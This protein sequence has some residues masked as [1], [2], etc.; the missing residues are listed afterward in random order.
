MSTGLF[1]IHCKCL[2]CVSY[3]CGAA[4]RCVRDKGTTR[5][6]ERSCLL[7]HT[8]GSTTTENQRVE[9]RSD[10]WMCRVPTSGP[11]I[12]VISYGCIPERFGGLSGHLDSWSGVVS[13]AILV[14]FS[15]FPAV[16]PDVDP[17]V[18]TLRV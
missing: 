8:R 5:E 3:V 14:I 13:K 16:D 1:G 9:G 2:L 7:W 17:D 15:I 12:S 10:A 6:R 18:M 11:S 4:M